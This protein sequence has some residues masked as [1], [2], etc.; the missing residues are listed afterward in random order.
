MFRI[1]WITAVAVLSLCPLADGA[2]RAEPIRVRID[3]TVV[4]TIS[5]GFLGFGYETSAVAQ[6]DYFTSKNAGL[7]R[8]YTNLGRHGLIRV[9]GNV[10]DHTRFVAQGKAAAKTERQVT[11][12]NQQNLVDLADFARATGWQ[13]MWGLNLGTGTRQEAVDEA[14]AVQ[15]V[16]GGQLH[17][18]EIGNEVDLM[19]KFSRDFD[20]YHAAFIDYKNAIRRRL[21]HA[22]FSGPDVAG[23]LV[24]VQKFVAT[25]SLD[26][27]LVTHHYYRSGAR[28]PGATIENLLLRDQTFDT[29]LEQLQTLCS[30]RHLAYRI[31]EVN[32]FSGGGK[33][34]VS[35]TFASALWCLDYL[36]NVAAHGGS[37]VNMETDINQL[38]FI[39]HYSPIV[40]DANGACSAR[41]EYYAMLAFATA[42]HGA[43]LKTTVG[44]PDNIN[45]TAYAT[46]DSG[47]MHFLTIIN[48]DLAQDA[49]IECAVPEGLS[50]AEVWSLRDTSADARTGV[51]F[52][53]AAVAAD[54]S[55][56]PGDR[57]R[58]SAADGVIRLAL[59]HAS[60]V[61]LK[62]K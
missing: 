49:I 34:G 8:L 57:D 56:T 47:G 40:H 9:G 50:M 24:F 41:P 45:L 33:Q 51:T 55:W 35:D 26:V 20:Q 14:V 58:I 44:N 52:A 2:Q 12:V 48:K 29:R 4:G 61:I 54:G 1:V 62:F 18:L 19:R 21:P 42:G 7:L 60:A 46:G 27:K 43:L 13:V 25:E 23:S 11:I 32:S 22:S 59:P 38:G 53:G 6:P 31:N 36:F 5:E 16:L 30:N 15:D 3:A 10:S 37:G 17:S 28:N 39:S